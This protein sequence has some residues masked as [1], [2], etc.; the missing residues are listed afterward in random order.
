MRR[1]DNLTLRLDGD[2]LRDAVLLWLDQQH[3]IDMSDYTSA[4]ILTTEGGGYS[5]TS[6]KEIED[7]KLG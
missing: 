4:A 6:R 1:T 5:I 3:G 2:D 7:D